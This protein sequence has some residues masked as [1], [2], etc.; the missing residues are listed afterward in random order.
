MAS[1]KGVTRIVALTVGFSASFTVTL[2]A[3]LN[4]RVTLCPVDSVIKSPDDARAATSVVLANAGPLRRMSGKKILYSAAPL[5]EI[6]LARVSWLV[7][8]IT[9][10]AVTCTMSG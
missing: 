10:P 6:V 1:G 9:C 7:M 4:V 2:P 3:R 8:V 5:N